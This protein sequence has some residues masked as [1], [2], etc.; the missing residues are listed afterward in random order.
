MALKE[1]LR[2]LASQRRRF[3]YRRLHVLLRREETRVNHKRIYRL[4]REEG[5]AVRRRGRK[6]VAKETRL[7]IVVPE[8]L[9][10]VSDALAWGRRMRLLC[11]IDTY[12][13]G[14]VGHRGGHVTARDACGTGPG[15]PRDEARSP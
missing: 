7:P 14:G 11:I 5:L 2:H 9:D 8:G 6:K 4:Y 12:T 1:R 3:V 13:R 10:F 15:P